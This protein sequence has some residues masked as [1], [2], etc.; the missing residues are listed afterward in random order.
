M[1]YFSISAFSQEK[2]LYPHID[3]A[4][5]GLLRYNS[6]TDIYTFEAYPHEG[7]EI[8]SSSFKGSELTFSKDGYCYLTLLDIER[9]LIWGG[10]HFYIFTKNRKDIANSGY[11][12]GGIW[13]NDTGFEKSYKLSQSYCDW[14][15][16][17]QSP[18]F[19]RWYKWKE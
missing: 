2:I 13:L 12:D 6:F 7:Y 14:Q 5:T 8:K 18:N 3:H 10:D 11:V 1:F 4:F 19:R 9:T 15:I 17:Y 16:Y